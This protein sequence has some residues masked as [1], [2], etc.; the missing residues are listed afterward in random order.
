MPELETC[1]TR[2]ELLEFCRERSESC[3]S[4]LLP[5]AKAG[6]EVRQN[7]IQL[8]NALGE[9]KRQLVRRDI[10]IESIPALNAAEGLLGNEAFWRVQEPGL[11]VFC[12]GEECR[13]IALPAVDEPFVTTGNA[14]YC[15]PLLQMFSQRHYLVLALA[16]REARLFESRPGEAF[17][18]LADLIAP[19]S[20]DDILQYVESE[21][22]LQHHSLEAAPT[23]DRHDSFFHGHGGGGADSDEQRVRLIEYFR[24]VDEALT[25]VYERARTN[26][27]PLIV[28]C[29]D[30]LF[31]LFR[32]VCRYPYLWPNRIVPSGAV[33]TESKL[34]E[35]AERA[36]VEEAARERSRLRDRIGDAAPRDFASGDP[37]LVAHA[38]REGF[39]E[40][41]IVSPSESL[42]G[43]VRDESGR[44]VIALTGDGGDCELTDYIVRMTLLNGGSV[45]LDE[46]RN[47]DSIRCAAL[48]RRPVSP[49]YFGIEEQ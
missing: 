4:M 44:P 41:A 38:A 15:K 21:R 28:A 33:S 35:L 26:K 25:P 16:Q 46:E 39:V 47:D 20:I 1:L 13:T 2:G 32:E 12:C 40:S 8:K 42:W 31:P 24:A 19:G 7:P 17:G 18:A 11:A 36:L 37:V 30:Y 3:I 48:F 14:F 45:V 43:A 6:T 5:M 9:V 23:K 34:A 29:V 49:E 22:Q 27:A 10:P